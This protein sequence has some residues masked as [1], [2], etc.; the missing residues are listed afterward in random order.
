MA[1]QENTLKNSLSHLNV[2]AS[3]TAVPVVIISVLCG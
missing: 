3:V 1:A 2:P